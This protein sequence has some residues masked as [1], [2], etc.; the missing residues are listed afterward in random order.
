[1]R[2]S[3]WSSDV[4]SSDLLHERPYALHPF[5]GFG[6]LFEIHASAPDMPPDSS[7]PAHVLILTRP[8][9]RVI[10]SRPTGRLSNWLGENFLVDARPVGRSSGSQ[11][12]KRDRKRVV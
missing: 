12:S 4:C 2:I 11:E 9:G 1:M 5:P 6:R 3:D 10:S 7:R 8:I